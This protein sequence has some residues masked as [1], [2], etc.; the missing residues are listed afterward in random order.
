MA[1]VKGFRIISLV[2]PEGNKGRSRYADTKQFT[3]EGSY[4]R[5]TSF[6]N[7]NRGKN[8]AGVDFL[9]ARKNVKR[10]NLKDF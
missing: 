7:P 3:K 8:V 10:R 6:G 4:L 2:L 9:D 1:I 5:S